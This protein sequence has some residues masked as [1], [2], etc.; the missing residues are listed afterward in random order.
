VSVLPV[1]LLRTPTQ[2]IMATVIRDMVISGLLGIADRERQLNRITTQT[3]A[4]TVQTGV[5]TGTIQT[6]VGTGTV[7]TGIGTGTVVK[8]ERVRSKE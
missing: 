4:G 3:G 8:G 2:D 5:G 7:R 1:R 6:G